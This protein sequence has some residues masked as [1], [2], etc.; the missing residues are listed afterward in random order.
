MDFTMNLS[1]D[2]TLRR[3]IEAHKAGNLQEAYRL[4]TVILQSQP[5]HPEANHNMGVLAERA[6]KAQDALLLFKIALKENPSAPQFWLSYINAL[7]NLNYLDKAKSVLNEARL[8]GAKG[9]V[10]DKLQ[11]KLFEAEQKLVE[12]RST[13]S[14]ITAVNLPDTVSDLKLD[15]AMKL[16]KR[17][18]RRC[19]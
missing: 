13:P 2:E 6:G 18:L 5:K 19:L 9:E 16:A 7:I 3:G 1:L 8:G 11:E 4:Y 15:Q 14:N 17:Q 12:C 10:F